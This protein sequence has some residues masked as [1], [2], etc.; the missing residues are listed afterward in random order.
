[1]LVDIRHAGRMS[2][3]TSRS[4]TGDG[5]SSCFSLDLYAWLF[6]SRTYQAIRWYE[7]VLR[8]QLSLWVVLAQGGA[9]HLRERRRT[10]G[11]QAWRRYRLAQRGQDVAHGTRVNDEGES[12]RCVRAGDGDRQ[13]CERASRRETWGFGSSTREATTVCCRWRL[14]AVGRRPCRCSRFA[15][16]RA[17][18]LSDLGRGKLENFTMRDEKAGVSRFSGFLRVSPRF[19]LLW[20]QCGHTL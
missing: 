18:S 8:R 9:L 16:P 12:A 5:S 4:T 13:Q 20:T 1:M 11:H 14:P 6:P 17:S 7:F 10:G 19:S 3:S 2:T 15:T